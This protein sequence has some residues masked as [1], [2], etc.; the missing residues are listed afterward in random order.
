VSFLEVLYPPNLDELLAGFKNAHLSFL[1]NIFSRL[2]KDGYRDY[3]PLKF[4]ELSYD[5]NFLRNAGHVYTVLLLL[6]GWYVCLRLVL[7]ILNKLPDSHEKLKSYVPLVEKQLLLTS[8]SYLTDVVLTITSITLFFAFAQMSDYEDNPISKA[9]AA[10]SLITFIM[11]VAYHLSIIRYMKI[12]R[13]QQRK[14]P[15]DYNKFLLAHPELDCFSQ[16]IHPTSSFGS[17]I[18]LVLAGR[19]FF[20]C[21]ALGLLYAM[22]LFALVVLGG[23]AAI[24]GV[25]VACYKPFHNLLYNYMVSGC[26]FCQFSLYLLIGVMQFNYDSISW[27]DKWVMGWFGCT[28]GVLASFGLFFYVAYR[29][30]TRGFERKELHA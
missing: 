3:A 25:I 15:S 26:C 30:V 4:Y 18:V 21:L 9:S 11:L 6:L 29:V 2:F 13:K 8:G 7:H 17:Y 20:V 12:V 16:S 10:L 5:V 1:P 23:I 22:P 27:R 14:H 28:L 24:F 19:K